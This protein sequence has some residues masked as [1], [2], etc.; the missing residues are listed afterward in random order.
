MLANPAYK[1]GDIISLKLTSGEEIIA[2]L[3][4]DNMM[5]F[6][7]S[8]PVSLIPTPQGSLG[9]VP[10]MF[11]VELNTASITLQKTAVAFHSL[12]R[13]EVADEYIKGTTGIKP[14]SSLVGIGNATNSKTV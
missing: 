7:L 13:K 2:R 4:E 14:A 3:V 5:D 12:T 6:K 11:S 8:K 9:M 10:A 1:Q